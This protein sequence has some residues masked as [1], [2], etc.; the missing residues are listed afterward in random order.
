MADNVVLP[1]SGVSAATDE[2]AVNGG[3]S[4]HVQYV[5]LVDGTANGTV[6]IPGGTAGLRTTPGAATTATLSNVND[7]SS[8]TSLLGS[9]SGRL[10]VIVYNDSTAI[11]YL[12]YGTTASTTS[13]TVIIPAGGTWEMPRPIYTGAIDGIWSANASGAARIT[14]LT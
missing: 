14:E 6:G 13:F 5:K 8:N 1:A 11:L 9:T 3:S 12:K 7:D 4:A 2:V 10:G